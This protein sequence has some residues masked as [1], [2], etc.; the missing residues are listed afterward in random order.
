MTTNGSPRIPIEEQPATL[1]TAESGDTI[2]IGTPQKKFEDMGFDEWLS[3]MTGNG[4]LQTIPPYIREMAKSITEGKVLLINTARS[5]GRLWSIRLAE[6]FLNDFR[7]FSIPS[8]SQSKLE[9]RYERLKRIW[10]F[11]D[12][13]TP[14]TNC[15]FCKIKLTKNKPITCQ[16]CENELNET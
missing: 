3:F 5:Q 16:N 6:K 10:S 8:G 4:F 9:T 14:R 15:I 12:D 7:V 13:K 2:L 1:L 11:G